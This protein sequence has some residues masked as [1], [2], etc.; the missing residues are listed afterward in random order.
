MI[1]YYGDGEDK[2]CSVCGTYGILK[3]IDLGEL[4]WRQ[5]GKTVW[6]ELHRCTS[7]TASWRYRLQ[8]KVLIGHYGDGETSL[9]QLVE[10]PSFRALRL[11]EPGTG[12]PLR[13]FLSRHPHYECSDYVAEAPLGAQLALRN[14]NLCQLTYAASCFDVVLTSDVLEHVAEPWRALAELR[15]VLAPGG[16]HVFTLPVRDPMP[17]ATVTRIAYSEGKEQ[18]LLPL[19]EHK[20]FD[21]KSY[22]VYTDFGADLPERLEA[23]G[24]ATEIHRADEGMPQKLSLLV[25]CSQ[26]V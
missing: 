6:I 12:G 13:P 8:A 25:F 5:R 9:A 23:Y 26:A 14:E 3:A 7:C 2:R 4:D 15:R 11:Y 18:R 24:F 17:P 21:G 1:P 19:I 16:R 10:Q 20:G 22:P